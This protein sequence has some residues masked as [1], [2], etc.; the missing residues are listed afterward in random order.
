MTRRTGRRVGVIATLTLLVATAFA[1]G[2]TPLGASTKNPCK[3]LSKAEIQTA[4][5][6]TVANPKLG[7]KT[8]VSQQCE[9]KVSANGDRPDGTVI[10]HVMFKGGKAAYTGLKRQATLYVPVE[11]VANSLYAEKL[12]VVNILKGD[13]FFGVQGNFVST[14]PLPIHF[15]DAKTQLTSLAQIGVKRV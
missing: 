15:Y 13:V 3:F 10:V 8:P 4:F 14:T 11:G 12:H 6:G 5:G 1:V 9:Y 7:L 2:A